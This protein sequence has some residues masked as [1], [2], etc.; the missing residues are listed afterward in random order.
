VRVAGVDHEGLAPTAPQPLLGEDD[1]RGAD[2]VA[3]EDTG[4]RGRAVGGD[5]AE[6]ERAAVPFDPGVDGTGPEP[7]RVGD[8]RVRERLHQQEPRLFA[9]GSGPLYTPI[10][11]RNG[12][13]HASDRQA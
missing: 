2:L 3:R 8:S 12:A 4:G 9:Y 5:D 10:L 7:G 13:L 1:R 6:V 11:R